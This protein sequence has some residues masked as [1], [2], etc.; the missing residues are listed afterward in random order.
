MPDLNLNVVGYRAIQPNWSFDVLSGEGAKI[1]GG[2][3]NPSGTSA[4][5]LALSPLGA[6]AEFNQAGFSHR[7]QP[8]TLCAFEISC[9]DILD[10]STTEGRREAQISLKEMACDFRYLKAKK[11]IPPT[12]KMVDFLIN[13]NKAGIVV[14]SFGNFSKSPCKHFSIYVIPEV[15]NRESIAMYRSPI[16][17]FGDDDIIS[18]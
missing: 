11:Q 3:F 8:T 5:Y 7:P 16:K 18:G 12:W 10:L 9:S 1:H 14:P 4:L 17:D 13:N 2:R 15:F 6:L